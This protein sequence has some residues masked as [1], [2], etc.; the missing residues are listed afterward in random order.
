MRLALVGGGGFR[1]PL[2]YR[3]LVRDRGPGRVSE[4]ALIDTDPQRLAVMQRV[5]ADQAREAEDAPVVTGH[6]DLAEGLAGADFVF[7]A[8]RVGGLA[9][10]VADEQVALAHGVIGQETIGAG[11]IAYALR[12]IPVAM[13]LARTIAEVAPQAW[14]IN[15][16]NP[17]GVITQ[18]MAQVL[19]DKVIGICD[20]PIGLARHVAGALGLAGQPMEIDYV[21]LNHLGWLRGLQVAGRQVLGDLLLDDQALTSFE[22]GRLFGPALLRDLS[23]IPNE[24]LYYYYF[25][26]DVLQADLAAADPRGSYLHQQQDAFYTSCTEHTA[27]P[28]AVWDQARLEREQTYGASVREAAGG[29]DRDEQDLESGGYDAV[30]LPS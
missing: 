27:H 14:T 26:R 1:V 13:D 23:A 28:F 10:R 15:F 17:A 12:T 20:S 25:A 6:T 16:T 29:M 3:T 8:M 7:S 21:G 9:G 4:L 19:G 22:E 5:L 2:V 30:A 18:A 11:G 24:Y